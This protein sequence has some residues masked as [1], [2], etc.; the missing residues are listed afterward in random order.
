MILYENMVVTLLPL[1]ITDPAPILRPYSDTRLFFFSVAVIN[2][3][4][5]IPRFVPNDMLIRFNSLFVW[6]SD[7]FDYFLLIIG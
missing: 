7:L 6:L 5:G 1:K 3:W 2:F 4:F